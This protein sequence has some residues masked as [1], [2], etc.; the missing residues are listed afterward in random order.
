MYVIVRLGVSKSCCCYERQA[1]LPSLSDPNPQEDIPEFR[2]DESVFG[3]EGQPDT[4]VDVFCTCPT[5]PTLLAGTRC[6]RGKRTQTKCQQK[7][8]KY[9]T[10]VRTDP[11]V[12]G[13]QPDL[14]PQQ[15]IY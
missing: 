2:A 3:I 6:R 11:G 9:D 14:V 1:Y 13:L 7:Y 5:A 12:A 15:Y 8:R 10:A 4:S